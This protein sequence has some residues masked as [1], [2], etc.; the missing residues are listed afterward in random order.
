MWDEEEGILVRIFKFLLSFDTQSS[1]GHKGLTK[2]RDIQNLTGKISWAHSERN[3]SGWLE[4]LPLV[5]LPLERS[6][7]SRYHTQNVWPL[8]LKKFENVL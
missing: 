1:W 4:E 2:S 3:I 8:L 7:R 6:R 5:N